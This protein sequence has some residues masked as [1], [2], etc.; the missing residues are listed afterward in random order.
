MKRNL[1][2]MLVGCKM[3]ADGVLGIAQESLPF[4]HSKHEEERLDD[5][6]STSPRKAIPGSE[7][8][9][10]SN[11]GIY[12]E[13]NDKKDSNFPSK[14]LVSP[15]ILLLAIYP[16]TNL[17]LFKKTSIPLSQSVC[18]KLYESTQ[19]LRID[20]NLFFKSKSNKI[21]DFRV[22]E[23]EECDDDI[24]LIKIYLKDNDERFNHRVNQVDRIRA[25]RELPNLVDDIQV[26]RRL[27][28]E[29]GNLFNLYH[30]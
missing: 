11:P 23:G 25:F 18:E 30:R 9:L 1:K 14:I 26:S 29:A 12:G 5:I 20:D 24:H 19:Y 7:N 21:Q 15:K 27:R 3:V 28:I 10:E 4:T 17:S 6:E 16:D 22:K 13:R 2:K 8:E